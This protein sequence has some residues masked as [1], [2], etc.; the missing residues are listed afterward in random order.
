MFEREFFE[1][2]GIKPLNHP[3]LKPVRK[4]LDDYEFFEM[5]GEEGTPSQRENVPADGAQFIVDYVR[6][7]QYKDILEQQN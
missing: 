2:F 5:K 6:V 4:N 7:Y 1:Q 3:W